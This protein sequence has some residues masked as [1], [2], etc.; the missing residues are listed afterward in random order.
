MFVG[1]R[2]DVQLTLCSQQRI[3]ATVEDSV[4]RTEMVVLESQE[5]NTPECF[6]FFKSMR[7]LGQIRTHHRNESWST[8]LRQTFFSTTMGDQIP[9]I[10]EKPLAGYSVVVG[11]FRETLLMITFTRVPPARVPRRLTT[12]RLT[13]SL[14]Y[15]AQHTKQ[16]PNR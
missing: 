7:W 5:E 12:G 4:L 15:F 3:V 14:T 16:K 2:L 11:S 10:V 1:S 8:S 13:N 6:L 9:V